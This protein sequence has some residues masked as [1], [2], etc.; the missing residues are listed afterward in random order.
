MSQK[1]PFA[2]HPDGSGIAAGVPKL[3]VRHAAEGYDVRASGANREI[4]SE[5]Q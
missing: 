1:Y 2:K 5:L 4:P 3:V